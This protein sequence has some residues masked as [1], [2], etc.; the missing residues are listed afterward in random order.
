MKILGVLASGQ[1]SYRGRGNLG[2]FL[3]RE[4]LYVSGKEKPYPLRDGTSRA[5]RSRGKL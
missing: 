2:L 1:A 4:N 3:G 5:A